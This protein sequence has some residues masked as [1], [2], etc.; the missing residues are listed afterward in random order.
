MF[1][2]IHKTRA[3]ALVTVSTLA[4]ATATAAQED[5]GFSIAIDGQT[6]AGDPRLSTT[7]ARED[8]KLER[9]KLRVQFDGLEVRPRLA[10]LITNARSPRA[11]E[12]MT[13][14]SEMNYPA[15]VTRGEIRI[16]DV[17]ARGGAR[18]VATA[19]IA[20]NG[21]ASLRVPEGETLVMTYRVYDKNG[22]F[23]ETRPLPL[24]PS[25][26]AQGDFAGEGAELGT[27]LGGIRRI[28]VYG[29]A[30]TVSG[31]DVRPGAVI[32]TLGER[33]RPDPSGNFVLQ[34]ILPAGDRAVA[35]KVTGAGE[36]TYIERDI[37]IPRAEWF[38]TAIV[39]LTFGRRFDDA[40]GTLDR[41]Y[42]Y[43]RIAGYAKGKTQSGWVL[44]GS[45]DTGEDD[46]SDLLRDLDEKDPQDV[47]IRLQRENAYPTYGDDSTFEE[48]APTDGKFFLRAEK[49]GS[50]LMWGNYTASVGG[51]Y[52]LRNER[53]LYGAQ[54]VYRSPQTTSRGQSRVTVEAYAASP[55]QLPGRDTF[56]GT[57]G[58]VYFL[59]RQ[60]VSVDTETVS[61]EIRD[62]D[63]GRVIET[64]GL[65]A[66]RDYRINY[67]QGTVVLTSP[68]S[69]TAA[70][71]TVVT[72]PGGAYDVVLVVNYE[73]TPVAG[74]VDGYS[75][76][77]R[78]EGWVTDNVR[79]G[80]TGVVEQTDIA[81]QTAQSVDL[82]WELSERSFI[83]L[84]YA[85]TEGPG[86]GS[87]FSADGG[88]II[89][90]TASAGVQ[91]GTGEGYAARLQLDFEDIGLQT[92]GTFAAYYETRDA[93]FSTLDYQTTADEELWGVSVGVAPTEQL[94]YRFYYDSFEN[95]DGREKREGGAELSYLLSQR[96]RLDFG[97]EHLTR[98]DP[99]AAAEDTGSRT[100][101]AIRATFT[102]SEDFAWY[103]FAQ[104]TLDRSGEL[105]KND[106]LGA[107]L[108]YRFAEGW[109][110]EGEVSDGSL[111]VAG[112][113]LVTYNSDDY[114]SV[115]L[116]Y[117]LDPGREFS[118]ATLVGRDRGNTSPGVSVA[119][120]RMSMS[121]Q[122][123]PMICLATTAR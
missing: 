83:A 100:D 70:A 87:S 86:F 76:G 122:R 66:G 8:R 6:V 60:D 25:V 41:T 111:G 119:C 73:F 55:D 53:T 101:A 107:G 26:D 64:R 45:I 120:A 102:E 36:N 96:V 94:A 63:T 3:F 15:Y 118:G 30:V 17:A 31:S 69:G 71:G 39:D 61:V 13:V 47:L 78:A 24:T 27:D 106:R 90:N 99:A 56:L 46:L 11:G 108:A 50:H 4:I 35:V 20:A 59:Q 115:Y 89:E 91:D 10:A 62:R 95:A 37:S 48:G 98:E 44:T 114:N 49:N 28:P 123:I 117:Q 97:V 79:L 23:D 32:D 104:T 93:G 105:E 12:T 33:V 77:G 67:L 29:G 58:S 81:D 42:S 22:R 84:E 57:G 2:K 5:S 72:E 1:G 16:T 51:G 68:L 85:Q 54:G 65:V 9:A 14:R 18:V 116:G 80:Y 121:T 21:E 112:K 74:D 7:K 109:T 43:G 113:A 92:P 75:Y 103:V 19:P 38:S 88:L 52:Y 82:L 34:R 40:D 110:F